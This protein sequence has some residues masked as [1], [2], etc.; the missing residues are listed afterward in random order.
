MKRLFLIATALVALTGTA[1]ETLEEAEAEAARQMR[2][3]SP[4]RKA[5]FRYTARNTARADR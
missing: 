1:H 5:N 4:H 2:N 3:L